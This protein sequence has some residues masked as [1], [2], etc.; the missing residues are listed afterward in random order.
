MKHSFIHK[1]YYGDIPEDK[2]GNELHESSSSSPLSKKGEAWPLW[3]IF[4]RSKQG[5][6]HKHVGML[7]MR[8]WPSNMPG[9]FIQEG[10]KELVSGQL[11]QNTFTHRILMTPKAFMNQP[12]IKF[13][14]ILLF[15]I[16]RM[17]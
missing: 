11:N 4:I 16:Y 3:E 14:V 12:M 10:W 2:G 9:M 6:D 1:L 13:T 7:L 17:K 8:R 15:M 5:L